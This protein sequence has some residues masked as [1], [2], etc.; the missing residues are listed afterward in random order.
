[1]AKNSRQKVPKSDFQSQFSASKII[2]NF[3]KKFFIEEYQSRGTF[4][5][6]SNCIK[7]ERLLF[8][9][10][11]KILAFFD[12]YFWPFNKSEENEILSLTLMLF[13]CRVFAATMAQQVKE[14]NLTTFK[15][16][17]LLLKQSQLA[18]Q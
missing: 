1:M 8:L 17:V 2:R 13:A 3:I 12:R 5:V 6:F 10:F 11:L 16:H 4:F 15:S 18:L 9:K 7:I 14:R